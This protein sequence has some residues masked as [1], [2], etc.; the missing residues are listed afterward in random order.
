MKNFDQ[1]SKGIKINESE[2]KFLN[3]NESELESLGG[4]LTTY[5][6][7]QGV[8]S[9]SYKVEGESLIVEIGGAVMIKITKKS[10]SRGG[11]EYVVSMEHNEDEEVKDIHSWFASYLA[12][13]EAGEAEY[14]NEN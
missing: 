2:I 13:H 6:E 7:D 11:D 5:A 9:A 1:F 10:I 14:K 12:A 4:E 8:S 3:E